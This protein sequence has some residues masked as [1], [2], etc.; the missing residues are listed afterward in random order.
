MTKKYSKNK[1][2]KLKKY[3][4]AGFTVTE[5]V[6]KFSIPKT[7]I[8]HHIKDVELP[9]DVL[10]NIK[11]R[12]GG[13]H[14][15]MLRNIKLAQE[16]ARVLSKSE[17]WHFVVVWAMLYWAEG[18]K[19]EFCFTNSDG[20]MIKSFIKILK[21]VLKVKSKDFLFI[22]RVV[23]GMDVNKCLNYWSNILD[24]NEEKIVLRTN[25]GV[26]R[27]NTEYGICKVFVKKGGNLV[28]LVW[29]ILEI[30]NKRI[31]SL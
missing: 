17:S 29:A 23:D 24:I 8:W 16:K 7:S 19:K 31:M 11:S 1:I 21:K 10:K 14:E 18:S 5:L 28:K 15:R 6:K 22:L 4:V 25:D 20:R 27:M 30:E 12:Q 26:L 9:K 3:R 13:S 2:E